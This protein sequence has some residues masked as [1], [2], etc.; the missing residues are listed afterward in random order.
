MPVA[1]APC[2]ITW[3][4]EGNAGAA[5]K[6]KVTASARAIR[7]KGNRRILTG[8]LLSMGVD[9]SAGAAIYARSNGKV[10]IGVARGAAGFAAPTFDR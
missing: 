7:W 1:F 3:N 9:T 6:K 10:K 4:P 8:S 5:A 2:V